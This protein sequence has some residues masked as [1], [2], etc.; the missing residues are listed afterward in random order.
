LPPAWAEEPAR[1]DQARVPEAVACRTKPEMALGL[2]DQ[3]RAWGVP[4]RGLVADADYGDNPNFLAGLESRQ[5][6]YVV[7]VRADCR[8]RQQRR[9]T[10]PVPRADHVLR[11]LP[12]WQWR[13]IRWRRG[14]TGWLRKTCVAVRCWRMTSAGQRPVGWLLGERT[15]RGQPEER[16]DYWSNLPAPATLA[17]LAG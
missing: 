2:L 16:Q 10:S 9:A 12:R 15:T 11:A 14:P 4:H 1:R 13:A 5:E 7:G 8:L 3:A 17:A 6:R